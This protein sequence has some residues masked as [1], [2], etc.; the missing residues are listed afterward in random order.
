M[1]SETVSLIRSGRR[2]NPPLALESAGEMYSTL[3]MPNPWDDT[4]RRR[5]ARAL[6]AG[7]RAYEDSAAPFEIGGRTLQRWVE[8]YLVEGTLTPKPKGGLAVAD[9]D[10]DAARADRRGAERDLRGVVLRVC[11]QS[12]DVPPTYQ[13]KVP[14]RGYSAVAASFDLSRPAFIFSL[15]R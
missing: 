8:G 10:A 7:K 11:Q 1:L 15:S 4:L 12:D 9:P 6:E 5:A 3:E 14:P 2:F 13:V